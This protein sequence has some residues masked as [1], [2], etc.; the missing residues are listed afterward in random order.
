MA[1]QRASARAIEEA[2][3]LLSAFP[4]RD[5]ARA[6]SE[7]NVE[8]ARQAYEVLATQGVEAFLE[9][10]V[11]PDGV[12]YTAPEWVE[13]SE[14]HGHDGVRFLYSIFADNF[15]DW[16]FEVVEIR[17]AGDSVVTLIEHGG[18]IKGTDVPI[19]QPMGI[20]T[21]D[22]REGG[23]PHKVHFFQTWQEALEAAGLS[24]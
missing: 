5:T 16:S 21:S 17:D 7:E 3:D 10:F 20:V 9:E 11:P 2:D 4:T 13:G 1:R 18:R 24:E 15:D 19:R 23:I 12:W 22:I 8:R 14:Y 6:M